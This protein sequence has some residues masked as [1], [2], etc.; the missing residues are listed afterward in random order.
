VKR[1]VYNDW[2]YYPGYA[3]PRYAASWRGGVGRGARPD[4][5]A[6]VSRPA[7]CGAASAPRTMVART[8][9]NSEKFNAAVAQRPS[10]FR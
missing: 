9:W 5:V 6:S 7:D 4:G 10:P 3:E 1:L 8:V 2:D